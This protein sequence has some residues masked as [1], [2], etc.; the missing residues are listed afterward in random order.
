MNLVFI[1]KFWQYIDTIKI[2]IAN[3]FSFASRNYWSI[4]G[5]GKSNQW[6]MLQRGRE[7]WRKKRRE[8]EREKERERSMRR[9]EIRVSDSEGVRI[10]DW[11]EKK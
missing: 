10:E 2:T 7:T 3:L 1:L 4:S 8:R 11:R 9:G 5:G 6:T